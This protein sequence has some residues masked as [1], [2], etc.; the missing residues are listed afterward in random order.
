MTLYPSEQTLI[1]VGYLVAKKVLQ[2]MKESAYIS[3][4]S[5]AMISGAMNLALL[6]LEN[7]QNGLSVEAEAWEN[8]ERIAHGFL[9][10]N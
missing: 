7:A 10:K 6:V 4:E 8:A 9:S 3:P 1:C 2:H 5:P